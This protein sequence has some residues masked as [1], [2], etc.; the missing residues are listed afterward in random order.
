M[1]RIVLPRRALRLMARR[2][3]CFHTLAP[4]MKQALV[5]G[6]LLPNLGDSYKYNVAKHQASRRAREVQ[7]WLAFHHVG[8]FV[9]VLP[10][11]G[12]LFD[13]NVAVRWVW[14]SRRRSRLKHIKTMGNTRVVGCLPSVPAVKTPR[15]CPLRRGQGGKAPSV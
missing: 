14:G 4:E 7:Q 6:R 13:G 8:G 5:N 2:S 3:A 12:G 1:A 10:P 11:S 9:S 15:D